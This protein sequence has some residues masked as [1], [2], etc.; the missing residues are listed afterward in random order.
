MK[1]NA[2]KMEELFNDIAQVAGVI[3][4]LSMCIALL[5]R[6]YD[7][8]VEYYNVD[9]IGQRLKRI[10]IEYENMGIIRTGLTY[11]VHPRYNAR[12]INGK[13]KRVQASEMGIDDDDRVL[14]RVHSLYVEECTLIMT[15]AKY[16]LYGSIPTT[17]AFWL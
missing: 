3:P 10:E 9:W 16:R 15:R 5:L 17:S 8:Y 11:P 12:Q 6:T 1:T 14:R 13:P 2:K 4:I 7:I